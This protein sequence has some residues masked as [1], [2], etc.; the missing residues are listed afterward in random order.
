MP[1]K[2]H[3]T[4]TILKAES[5]KTPQR[6]PHLGG[7]SDGEQDMCVSPQTAC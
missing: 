4:T 5:G 1:L 2:T 6:L 3:G 7:D